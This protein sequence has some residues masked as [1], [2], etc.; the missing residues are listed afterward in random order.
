MTLTLAD[1]RKLLRMAIAKE[2]YPGTPETTPNEYISV[3]DGSL[4]D[5]RDW[6]E[7]IPLGERDVA[8]E[9]PQ[10]YTVAGNLR[11][12]A[13]V[14]T[15]GFGHIITGVLGT[16]TPTRIA[17]ASATYRHT[18]APAT[19]LNSYT[20]WR[21]H[22]I[23]EVAATYCQ[24]DRVRLAQPK[25]QRL[26]VQADLLGAK[27]AVDTH[28][29]AWVG[30][31]GANKVFRSGVGQVLFDDAVVTEFF[32]ANIT[33]E[34]NIDVNEI[35][36]LGSDYP[37]HLLAGRR[38]ISGDFGFFIPDAAMLTKFWG[39][40]S[41]PVPWPA[42][43]QLDFLWEGTTIETLT[44]PTT[45]IKE[46]GVG[47]STLTPSGTYSGAGR[48]FYEVKVTSSGTP[49][50]FR[51]RK[52]WGAWS[53]EVEVTGGAQTLSDAIA[54]TFSSTSLSAVGD[55]WSFVVGTVPYRLDV[56]VP[57]ARLRTYKEDYGGNRLAGR[58]EFVATIADSVY[59]ADTPFAGNMKLY[60]TRSTA[61]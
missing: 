59:G 25:R 51:W 5:T 43:A 3:D 9:T 21:K 52:N 38:R 2:T 8:L 17:T 30:I 49:D 24:F 37:T 18:I 48:A 53:A 44:T 60:N 31:Q 34:N 26:G 40:A 47:T 32:D 41:G 19:I 22:G 36:P 58:C 16:D 50:K 55:R 10:P 39:D 4:Q 28:F 45:A 23:L 7:Y 61:Y 12:L 6:E 56:H 42:H 27:L 20:L 57:S 54:V 1:S 29:G 11:T 35:I 13:A 33:F 14:E 46:G 15:Y